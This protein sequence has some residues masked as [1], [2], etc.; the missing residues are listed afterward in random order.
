MLEPDAKKPGDFVISG[1]GECRAMQ[2]LSERRHWI[3]R[4]FSASEKSTC[5]EVLFPEFSLKAVFGLRWA[6]ARWTR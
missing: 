1:C 2:D 3:D 5:P 4:W 6:L